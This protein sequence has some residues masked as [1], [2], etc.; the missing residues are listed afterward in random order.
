MVN[1]LLMLQNEVLRNL[2]AKI[3]LFVNLSGK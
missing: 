1:I 3:I 2:F